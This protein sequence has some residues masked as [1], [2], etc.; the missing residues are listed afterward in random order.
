MRNSF[1][2]PHA[3]G[4]KIDVF[5]DVVQRDMREKAGGACEGR[6]RETQ[7]SGERC[8][9]SCKAGK[10]RLNQ[11]TSGLNW[12]MVFKRRTGVDT[13]PNFQQRMT[14]NPGSSDC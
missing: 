8:I 14:L 5:N 1:S 11:T 10:T 13:L 4:G 2:R 9:G 7:K 12:R 6:R 3:S